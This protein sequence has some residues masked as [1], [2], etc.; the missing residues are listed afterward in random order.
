MQDPIGRL[1]DIFQRDDPL[2]SDIP[3]ESEL[4][5]Q[6]QNSHPNDPNLLK[7]MIKLYGADL[8]KWIAI[9]LFY[10]RMSYPTNE[11]C[12][13]VL[14]DT[15]REAM[16]HVEE[17][18]GRASV[19]NWLFG[20]SYHIVKRQQ[21]TNRFKDLFQEGKNN[22]ENLSGQPDR[23][24][25]FK[26]DHLANKIRTILILRYLF[27]LKL[28]DITSILDISTQ[29]IQQYLIQGRNKLFANARLPHMQLE[30]QAY[31]DGLLEE[32]EDELKQVI[33]HL[34]SCDL[35][36]A[37]TTKISNQED[38]LREDL[39]KR[40]VEPVLS[41]AELDKLVD[42][43][44]REPR[45]PNGWWKG[46]FP[47]RQASW[48]LGLSILFLGLAITFIRMTPVEREFPPVEPTATAE[49][50]GIVN[51]PPVVN[52]SQH[53][54]QLNEAPQYI[55][56]AF[57]SDGK[58]AVFASI[59][60]DPVTQMN[61]L[62]TIELYNRETNSIQIIS[63]NKTEQNL[64]WVWWDVVP[65]I[66]ADGSWIAYTT[67]SN[68]PDITGDSCKTDSQHPCLDIFLY[69]RESGVTKRITQSV[70]G[71]AANG[72]SFSPTVSVDGQWV[73]FWSAAS[74]LVEGMQGNCQYDH[75]I[76]CLYVY[77]YN[78]TSGKIEQIPIISLAPG[79]VDGVDRI[80]LTAD[81][82]LVGFT[83]M[84]NA[85][86]QRILSGEEQ[87]INSSPG[88][89]QNV[90]TF[91]PSRMNWNFL[92][93]I[94][95]NHE[96]GNY[97]M[98][99]QTQDGIRGNGA[100]SSPGLSADGRY[101]VFSSASTN[102]IPGD[103]N[104]FAD[105]FLRDRI[106]GKIELIS[107]GLKGNPSNGESGRTGWSGTFYSL[108]ISEDG[109]YIIYSSFATNLSQTTPIK[110][111]PVG[112][113]CNLLYLYDREAKTI[114]L[115]SD[116]PPYDFSYFPQIS[117]DGRWVSFMQSVNYC[118]NYQFQCSD[119][120]FYDRQQA[121]TYNLTKS[122]E[123]ILQLPWSYLGSLDIPAEI[124]ERNALTFSPDDSMLALAGNDSMVRIWQ[125]PAG[126]NKYRKSNPN[127]T[128]EV[129]NREYYTSVVFSPNGKWLAAGT[130]S[131]TVFIWKIPE[132]NLIY[133]LE[134]KTGPIK[135]LKFSPDGNQLVISSNQ[136]AEIW[137]VEGR[138]LVRVNSFSYGITS[139]YDVAISPK[140]DLI[141][142]AQGDGT[143]WLQS[144][145]TGQVVGR[146][147]G[148]L[149]AVSD[150]A[151]SLDG[152]LLAT[153]S[154][155]GKINLWNIIGLE[156]DEISINPLNTIWTDDLY[157]PMSFSPDN[158]YLI[159]SSIVGGMLLWGVIDG[160]IYTLSSPIQDGR[161]DSLAFSNLGDRLAGTN[162][163]GDVTIWGIQPDS[164]ST[165]FVHAF[166]D[167]YGDSG[168]IPV[169]TANDILMLRE[170]EGLSEKEHLNLDQAVNNSD[171]P[172]LV[173]TCLPENIIFR[174]ARVN[175][176]ES[177]WLEYDAAD[178]GGIQAGLYIYEQ[179][180]GNTV[181]PTMTVGA[182]AAINQ[183][184]LRTASGMEIAD[185]VQ[186]DWIWSRYY[187]S[188]DTSHNDSWDWYI[189]KPT[190]RLRWQQQGIFI[191]LYYQV[192]IPFERVVNQPVRNDFVPLD[193][194]LTQQDLVQI[195][196]GMKL[197]S[198]LNNGIIQ[199]LRIKSLVNTQGST[200]SSWS[201]QADSLLTR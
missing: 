85:S 16:S 119:V 6:L 74:N 178:Q 100:S 142:S 86:V 153:R 93:A 49:L 131:H 72:D 150:M 13:A 24:Q 108:N 196:Q 78:Q 17:F 107:Y 149:V 55:D 169:A 125:L 124:W 73:A 36:K 151:F 68:D 9:L 53:A 41:E 200:N 152:S 113:V 180:I 14:K 71:T 137:Q 118:T 172:L 144:I 158:R 183:V 39:Q 201:D 31:V 164:S 128:L 58:W 54:A 57:S 187:N 146:L 38:S 40:W 98:E 37:I 157:G 96:T 84:T 115:I 147:G 101:V 99:N 162:V 105:V 75:T 103:N 21:P 148:S 81:G 139:M 12:L 61:L 194:L 117:A 70:V 104:G 193:K 127:L 79:Y 109:R 175:L 48:I 195:A 29:Q 165:Y 185:Y 94:V 126:V 166:R 121:W 59:Q 155:E 168:P 76:L 145:P 177:V 46:N 95:Y 23:N 182:S 1:R 122:G 97:E 190:Q 64:P 35:C 199:N 167:A 15:F 176:D 186:G 47:V 160:N 52:A 188:Q 18:H 69:N 134:G 2:K 22:H 102:L 173:P 192:T 138:Q 63:E 179:V 135:D 111:N 7:R 67:M 140:G 159:S 88:I 34:E 50:P 170:P 171:F 19:H 4:A 45:H 20:I 87:I 62:P 184:P 106:T 163:S 8:E 25:W 92:E 5:F 174:D 181:P 30:I 42:E 189:M 82:Q 89:S 191:A 28:R 90:I 132:G 83:V 197:Y 26:F 120:M 136:E 156:A 123:G 130:T 11:K 43:I 56:P 116:L 198:E 110:C 77:L 129:S 80:S 161:L 143:V 154:M 32:G 141:A 60:V 114:E 27:D 91:D 33:Q 112:L 44:L 66:S 65:S 51:M 10:Q 133:T 3:E